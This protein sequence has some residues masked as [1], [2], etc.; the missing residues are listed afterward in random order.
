MKAIQFNNLNKTPIRTK[1]WV[2][3]NDISLGELNIGE[4]KKV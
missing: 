2:N 1:S 4:I 3:I